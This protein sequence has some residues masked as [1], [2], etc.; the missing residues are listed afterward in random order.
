MDRDYAAPRLALAAGVAWVVPKVR[1]V[2][3]ELLG[4]PAGWFVRTLVV[5]GHPTQEGLALKAAAGTA[6]LPREEVVFE[7]RWPAEGGV[8]PKP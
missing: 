1:G 7:G 2:V 5:V 8:A 6:R 3:G 4:L